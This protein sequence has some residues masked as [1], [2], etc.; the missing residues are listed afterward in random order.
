MKIL[1]LRNQGVHQEKTK[2]HEQVGFVVSD[3][4]IADMEALNPTERSK[5]MSSMVKEYFCEKTRIMNRGT[6]EQVVD[7]FKDK[8]LKEDGP[9]FKAILKKMCDFDGVK[10]TW[11]L[12]DEYFN[13]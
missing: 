2:S 13:L 4:C 1:K 12:K 6:T 3:E 7:Y 10:R 11:S 8:T 9:K 5:K